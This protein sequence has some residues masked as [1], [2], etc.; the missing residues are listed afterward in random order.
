M[1]SS[2]TRTLIMDS[3][4]ELFAKQGVHTTST[5]SI[6]KHAGVASG[7]IFV[8]FK[9]KQELVDEL[10]IK[11]KSEIID[12]LEHLYDW[13]IPL[14]DNIILLVH[15]AVTYYLQ[16]Y[17]VYLFL[18]RLEC[19]TTVSSKA[20]HIIHE[21]LSSILEFLEQGVLKGEIKDLDKGLLHNSIYALINSLV[22][23]YHS[24]NTSQ[25][26]PDDLQI[27]WDAISLT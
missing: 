17:N 1:S 6:A 25:V 3:A 4:L 26:D 21:K 23:Y 5:N 18:S 15:T 14:K 10:Y 24:H 20:Q 8:H 13:H 27:V 22:E 2:V 16:N 9:S 11:Y 19:A 7:T 12:Q